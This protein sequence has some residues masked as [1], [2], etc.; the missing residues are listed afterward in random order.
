MISIPLTVQLLFKVSLGVLLN[1]YVVHG[2]KSFLSNPCCQPR[3]GQEFNQVEALWGPHTTP[4]EGHDTITSPDDQFSGNSISRGIFYCIRFIGYFGVL[5]RRTLPF[6][7]LAAWI[8]GYNEVKVITEP[9][10]V[11]CGGFQPIL[12]YCSRS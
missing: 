12:K 3:A 9:L 7:R 2:P 11:R 4:Q 6:W 1:V 8:L 10:P 5:M